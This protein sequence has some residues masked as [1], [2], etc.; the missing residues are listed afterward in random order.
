MNKV[1]SNAVEENYFATGD[2]IEEIRCKLFL[3]PSNLLIKK[4]EDMVM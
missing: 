1:L 2:V 3:K 4:G